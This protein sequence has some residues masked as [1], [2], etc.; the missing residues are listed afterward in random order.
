MKGLVFGGKVT[1]A[2][3][4]PFNAV[5]RGTSLFTVSGQYTGIDLAQCAQK[6]KLAHLSGQGNGNFSLDI[7]P[8]GKMVIDSKLHAENVRYQQYHA[9]VPEVSVHL[10]DQNGTVHVAIPHAAV[11]SDIGSITVTNGRYERNPAGNGVMS[12]PLHAEHLQMQC[13]GYAPL[14]GLATID[15]TLEGDPDAPVLH[16]RVNA[17]DGS[18]L[19]HSFTSAHCDGTVQLTRQGI[20]S[21]LLRDVMLCRPGI[22]VSIPGGSGFDPRHGMLGIHAMV[23]VQGAPVD[24]VL[25]LF[26]QQ[27]PWQIDGGTEAT[28]SAQ[29]TEDGLNVTGAAAIDKPVVHIPRL[30]GDYAMPLDRIGMT[31]TL[32][33][34]Q[35]QVQDLQLTRGQT[36]LH[37]QGLLESSL[38]SPVYAYLIYHA[39]HARLQD[40]PQDLFRIPLP[41]S[42]AADI[43]G[44][45]QGVLDGN[46]PTPL[47]VQCTTRSADLHAA[48]LPLGNGALDL[49]YRYRPAD[50]ELNIDN[51]ELDNAAVQLRTTGLYQLDREQMHG[52][53][54]ALNQVNL[55]A[56]QRLLSPGL[57]A[58]GTSRAGS[59]CHLPAGD[60]CHSAADR[61]QALA[62]QLAR[63]P[64]TL[65]WARASMVVCGWQL[66]TSCRAYGIRA[67]AT[68]PGRPPIAGYPRCVVL[69][70]G[71]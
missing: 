23:H 59:P 34:R 9:V 47:T 62:A 27:S 7:N 18:L 68:G 4:A 71:E 35:V 44:T 67:A 31:F 25:G 38:A 39:D 22:T 10:E 65:K 60:P 1:G 32:N 64:H 13:F 36:T 30:G 5:H 20:S 52:V 8:D 63:F 66:R 61:L 19:A 26:Q 29:L 21:L 50:A 16:A 48:G 58:Q 54:L 43:T 11:Q 24:A 45:L 49:T 57:E 53:Q 12:L 2:A 55:S 15:G 69:A 17:I 56:L 41:L 37:A 40:M 6:L 46:G 42:G 3:V 70:H 51:A 33:G 28:L 14:T